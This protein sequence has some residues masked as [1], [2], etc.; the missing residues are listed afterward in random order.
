VIW[1]I[2]GVFA[3]LACAS[4]LWMNNEWGDWDSSDD[5]LGDWSLG[6]SDFSAEAGAPD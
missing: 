1:I 3:V 4:R 2:L 6:E 5:W